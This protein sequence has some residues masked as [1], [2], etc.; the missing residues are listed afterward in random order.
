MSIVMEDVDV[1]GDFRTIDV[2]TA[3]ARSSPFFD[4]KMS[5]FTSGIIMSREQEL[6]AAI[7][8]TMV[9]LELQ[10]SLTEHEPPTPKAA[11]REP[12]HAP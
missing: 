7:G 3:A 1:T 10:T 11:L 12:N 2:P 6:K 5:S 8:A 4:S 9:T